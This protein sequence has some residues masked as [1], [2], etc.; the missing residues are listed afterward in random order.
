MNYKFCPE[1]ILRPKSQNLRALEK[2]GLG[3]Y[4]NLTMYFGCLE[5]MI[6]LKPYR[7][8]PSEHDWLPKLRIIQVYYI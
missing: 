6:P 2:T 1:R 5:I 8:D 4:P 3:C 7:R